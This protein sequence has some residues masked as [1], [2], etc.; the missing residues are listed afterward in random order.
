MSVCQMHPSH[1][2]GHKYG[3]GINGRELEQLATCCACSVTLQE[4]ALSLSLMSKQGQK[5]SNHRAETFYFPCWACQLTL[6]GAGNPQWEHQQTRSCRGGVLQEGRAGIQSP[7]HSPG[8][9]EL[10]CRTVGASLQAPPGFRNRCRAN[11]DAEHQLLVGFCLLALSLLFVCLC[12][13]HCSCS[14]SSSS[15]VI[16]AGSAICLG[17]LKGLEGGGKHFPFSQS[18]LTLTCAAPDLLWCWGLC[19]W[20]S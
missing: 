16:C 19:V 20:A 14:S 10:W 13:C 12:S 7:P 3:P 17:M 1:M 8:R 6:S 4:P 15:C 5:K 2:K 9:A 18:S 11:R